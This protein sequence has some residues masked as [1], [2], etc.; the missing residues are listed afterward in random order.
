MLGLQVRMPPAAWISVSFE[1][2]VLPGSGT[3]PEESYWA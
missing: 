1:S 2:C 3:L